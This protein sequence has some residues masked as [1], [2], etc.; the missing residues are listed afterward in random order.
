M[1]LEH[2]DICTRNRDT[3][4]HRTEVTE[5]EFGICGLAVHRKPDGSQILQLLTPVS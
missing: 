2:L 1:P 4:K 3:E 5:G